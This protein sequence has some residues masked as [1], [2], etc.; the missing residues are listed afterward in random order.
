MKSTLIWSHCRSHKTGMVKLTV[1]PAIYCVTKYYIYIAS[2]EKIQRIFI[3]CICWHL[4]SVYLNQRVCFTCK[5]FSTDC[6]LHNF[7]LLDKFN[8]KL[9]HL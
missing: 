2:E 1:K 7:G 4:N 6:R 3:Y 5:G 9:A 8:S